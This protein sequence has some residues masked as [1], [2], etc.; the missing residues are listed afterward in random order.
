ME[1]KK[2]SRADSAPEQ[3]ETAYN[4][5]VTDGEF[6][7]RGMEKVEGYDRLP[8]PYLENPPKVI[9]ITVGRQLFVDDFL[10]DK[11]TFVREYHKPVKYAGNPILSPETPL[12]KGLSGHSAMAAPFSDGVWYDGNDGVFKMWYH[13]GWFD[14]T[15]YAESTDGIHWERV[16]CAEDGSNRVIPVRE[17]IMRDGGAV[18]LNRYYE[19]ERPYKM[20]LYVR[21]GGG[22]IWD[23]ADGKAWEKQCNTGSIGDRSTVFYNPFRKKW[24]YSMR[25]DFGPQLPVRARSYAEADTLVEGAPLADPVYWVRAD[26]YDPMLASVGDVPTLYNLDAVAYESVMLGAFTVFLGPE[27]NFCTETGIPKHTELQF[28]Y[29]RD[30]FHW[31]RPD[32]RSPVIAPEREN[33]DSWERGYVHSN[34]GICVVNGDEL[35]FYY[36]A[37]RGDTSKTRR[38]T[39]RDGMYDN[40]STGLAILRR[41]GFASLN[42][43]GYTASLK[44]RPL[45]FSGSCL[46]VNGDFHNGGLRAAILDENGAP[47]PGYTL[48]DC[49]RM[50]ADS[51][52]AML[53]WQGKRNLEELS[54]SVI[55]ICFEGTNG[56]LY[57][58]WIADDENGHSRGYLA[59]GEV[60]KKGLCDL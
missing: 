35:W 30:G 58:F 23:S 4:G 33:A 3:T 48:D 11:S 15:A 2:Q 26:R 1:Q 20:F 54:G 29:S 32:D 10:I 52:K 38:P 56:A 14:G 39:E 22:E 18:V 47:I 60:G 19:E 55:R 42:A 37:F 8:V 59:A 17:G 9:D 6:P 44:T 7:P 13:A 46:F 12:E 24:V 53:E 31:S 34:N 57:A 40:A 28:A 51:T 43:C 36:T 25:T 16:P 50:Q 49:V 41:D 45:R 5:I 21:P 27:N